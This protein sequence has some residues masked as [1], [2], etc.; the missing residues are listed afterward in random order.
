[1][2]RSPLLPALLLSLVSAACE[3]QGIQPLD[4][5]PAPDDYGVFDIAAD[6]RS[7]SALDDLG[8]G[9][10]RIQTRLGEERKDL[11]QAPRSGYALWLTVYHRDRSNIS[12]K[13]TFDQSSRGGFPPRDHAEYARRLQERL[14]PIVDGLRESGRDPGRWLVVQIGNEVAPYDR[15]GPDSPSRFWHGT[16]AQ[17]LEMLGTAYDAV[18]QID[19]GIPVAPGG[20]SSE[21]MQKVLE[22]NRIVIDWVEDLLRLGRYDVLDIHLYHTVQSVRPKVEWL[23]TRWSGPLAAT[24]VGGPDIRTGAAYTETAH[25]ADLRDRLSVARDA[26]VDRI[27]WQQLVENPLTPVHFQNMALI[28]Q[29]TWRR[30]PA[31]EAYR[32]WISSNSGN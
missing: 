17:Y 15:F 22:G 29:G 16:A 2:T 4:S 6:Q 18:K 3:P 1:M 5:N 25:V 19:D 12:D 32:A 10:V 30:K 11:T 7:L 9:W 21:M 24:E 20:V 28:E 23:R 31:F 13:D 27:F 14:R 26:G 8:V